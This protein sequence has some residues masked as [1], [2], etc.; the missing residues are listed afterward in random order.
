MGNF[1]PL[2]DD[3]DKVVI[4]WAV[5]ITGK[6]HSGGF[7]AHRHALV[8]HRNSV[9]LYCPY[10]VTRVE[11]ESLRFKAEELQKYAQSQWAILEQNGL[12]ARPQY[13][14]I[15]RAAIA[16]F[17]ASM[18]RSH[19]ELVFA[20]DSAG[21]SGLCNDARRAWSRG[22]ASSCP[23]LR[24]RMRRDGRRSAWGE[25]TG[26]DTQSHRSPTAGTCWSR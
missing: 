7:A 8:R 16:S 26:W 15:S 17:A 6:N 10:G 3:V 23:A 2:F 19:A 4:E 11:T 5:R 25:W 22:N 9:N 18:I 20:V 14:D 24:Q 13:V 21:V 12:S 1:Y